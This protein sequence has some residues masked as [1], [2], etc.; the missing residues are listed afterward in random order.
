MSAPETKP[1]RNAR[2]GAA[3]GPQPHSHDAA[4][5]GA[6][7]H[8]HTHAHDHGHTQ[9]HAACE[10]H[11][12]HVGGLNL[13][14]GRRSILDMLCA[15]G[16][17][18]GAYEMI[19]RL[20]DARGRRPAPISVY[21]A[22]DYLLENG[23]VHR[24]ATRNAFLACAHRHKASDPTVFLICE[25]CGRV[26]E[27]TSSSVGAGL[28]ALSSGLGFAANAQVIEVSGLCAACAEA[29]QAR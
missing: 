9:D 7:E 6:Q 16:K 11:G 29:K 8:A 13:T 26:D 1:R 19:D 3:P 23:L 22:L 4:H 2:R 28:Q 12:A 24:L 27:T 18:L 5:D 25:A 17:P 14:P 15:A 10:G 20:V 21:R